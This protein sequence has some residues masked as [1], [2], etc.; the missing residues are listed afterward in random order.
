M[1]AYTGTIA[2]APRWEPGHLQTSIGYFTRTGVM[3]QND[4]IT[5]A[6]L[7]P[8]NGVEIHN[9]S[10]SSNGLDTNATPTATVTITD[11]EAVSYITTASVGGAA[12]AQV[13]ASINTVSTI[14]T[15]KT[16]A[17]NIVATFPAAFATAGS[18]ANYFIVRVSYYCAGKA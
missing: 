2:V 12:A 11:T 1:T 10:F 7:I 9:V 18:G 4:T 16:A 15:I 17:S 13:G 6:N 3:A 14:G 5:F 8:A